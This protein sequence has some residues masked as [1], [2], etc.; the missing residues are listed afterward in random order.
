MRAW[1][2]GD[3]S[4]YNIIL[5]RG[6][7]PQ[8]G[9]SEV[10][11]ALGASSA[12]VVQTAAQRDGLQ[13]AASRQGLSR[14]T[15][16]ATLVLIATIL[17]MSIAMGTMILQRR[18]RLASMKVQ[19]YERA[20]LWRALLFESAL[21]LGAGCSIRRRLW[22]LRPGADQPRARDRHGLPSRLLSRGYERDLEL[23]AGRAVAVAIVALPDIAP[24]AC[25][26]TPRA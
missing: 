5:R 14:L 15:Q 26:L 13:R 19:G 1:G 6:V 25:P 2:S 18:P 3:P 20:V 16:I 17:A 23:C 10:Q 11:R 9:R 12:L 7:S 8:Q 22:D 4:A 24:P 21:L